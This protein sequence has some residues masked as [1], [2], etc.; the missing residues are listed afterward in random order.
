MVS[1]VPA[2]LALSPDSGAPW[3][4]YWEEWLLY[5]QEGTGVAMLGLSCRE[6]T[7]GEGLAQVHSEAVCSGPGTLRVTSWEVGERSPRGDVAEIS[8]NNALPGARREDWGLA[9]CP[10]SVP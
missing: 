2:C 1:M 3:P 9:S 7:K 8:R 10:A 6:G 4:P 5:I